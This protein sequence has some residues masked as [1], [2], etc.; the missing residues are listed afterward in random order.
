MPVLVA[1]AACSSKGASSHR[2]DASLEV[3][4]QPDGNGAGGGAAGA[5]GGSTGTGGST[6]LGGKSGTGGSTAS[7]GIGGMGGMGG[8]GGITSTGGISGS[9]GILGTGG[10]GSGGSGTG[11][12]GGNGMDASVDKPKPIMGTP[13]NSQDDCGATPSLLFCLAPGESVGCGACRTAADQCASDADCAPDGG[14]TAGTKICT[15]P[16]SAECYCYA[17]KRCLP[18]CRTNLACGVGQACNSSNTCEKTCV[19]G[20]GTCA[21]DFACA[22]SGFCR[23]MSCASDSQ[24]SGACVNGACY[25]SRGACQAPSA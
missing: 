22:A 16:A 18:G 5:S 1:A 20:D 7:G 6:A 13:C 12:A 21:V 15:P 8:G 3:G 11:G 10:S 23:R 14:A 25:G 2:Q 24:C 4:A 19:P 17:I 9:G